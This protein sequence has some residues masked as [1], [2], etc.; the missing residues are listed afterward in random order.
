MKQLPFIFKQVRSQNFFGTVRQHCCKAAS[1]SDAILS[2]LPHPLNLLPYFPPLCI[3]SLSTSPPL[4]V[5]DCFSIPLA[6]AFPLTSLEF[7]NEMPKIFE[8]GTLNYYTLSCLIIWILSVFR[9]PTL[10]HLP[11]FGSMDSLLCDLIALTPG[12]ALCLPMTRTLAVA[13]SFLSG[14]ACLS[15]NFLPLLSFCL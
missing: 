8:P 10:T 9:N 11:L 3:S 7:F 4:H 6:S 15:L 1:I 14:R 12:L 13:S 5:S 2:I